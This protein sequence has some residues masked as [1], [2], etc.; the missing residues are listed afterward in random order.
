MT[1]SFR[2]PALARFGLAALIGGVLLSATARADGLAENEV[3]AGFILNFARYT[4]WPAASLAGKELVIC[5][6]AALPLSGKLELLQGRQV[7]GR[8]VRVRAPARPG[9]WRECHVLFIPGSEAHGLDVVR[10]TAGELPLLTIGDSEGF[11]QAGGMIGMHPVGSR[12][13]FDV[14]NG[15]AQRAGLKFSSQMLKLATEVL[16]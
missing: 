3:K 12:I 5:S 4:E 15:A 1:A 11:V 10:R 8:D 2:L 9:E 16:P 6:P 13:R 14:N 7:Q